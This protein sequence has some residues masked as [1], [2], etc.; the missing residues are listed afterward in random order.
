MVWPISERGIASV[1]LPDEP[2][3]LATLMLASHE[4]GALQPVA[5]AV[6]KLAGVPLHCDAAQAIGKIPVHFAQLGCTTLSLS[7]HKFGGPKGI[8]ALLVRSGTRLTPLL[9]GGGQQRGHRPGTESVA[10]AVG[11]A[12][13]L[14]AALESHTTT[15]Q[16]LSDLRSRFWQ[17]LTSQAAPV[18]LNG[19]ELGA[20]DVIPTT[21]NVAFPGIRADLLL[22]RC[23]L[24]GIACSAGAACA[25]G[26]L[27]PSPGLRAMGLPLDRVRSSV[28]FS[29]SSARTVAEIEHAAASIAQIVRE[30]RPAS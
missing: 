12:T 26:S 5:E 24:A 16:H 8:G 4:T 18:L 27:L 3:H 2:I 15:Y 29:F 30:L 7:A 9:H 17:Q 14:A 10:L 25:S 11:L 21:L 22:M 1:E 19:P 28:R 23:D 6:Q 20:S 13:A